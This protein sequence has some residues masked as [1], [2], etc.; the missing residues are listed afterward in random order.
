MG[1]RQTRYGAYA[2]VYILVVIAIVAAANFLANRYNR[3]YDSTA[4]KRYSL[5]DQTIKIVS[6]LKQDVTIAYF[7]E[8][9]ALA[10]GRDLLERY[11]ALSPKLKVEYNDPFKKPQLAKEYGITTTGTTVL[12]SGDKR[13]EARSLSE[14][15][16]TSA[17]VRLLKTGDRVACF[18]SGAGEHAL[19]ENSNNSYSGLKDLFEKNNYKTS[20]MNLLEKPEISQ[21]CSLVVVGGPK[22]DYPQPVVDALKKYVEA[23]GRALLLLDPPLKTGK[24]T[25]ADNNALLELARS[26]GVTLNKDMVVDTS[27]VGQLYGMGPEVALATRYENHA[28]VREM[29]RTAT[30]FPLVRSLE[31]KNGDKT[32]VEKLVSTSKNSLAA[33]NLNAAGGALQ[34]P[35]GEAQSYLIAAAGTY[36][37]G[38]QKDG[39][40]VDGRFVVAGSSDWVTNYALGFGGNRDLVMNMTNWLTNDED[41]ISIRPKDPEDRRIQMTRNQMLMV[42]MVSQF[43]IPLGAILLGFLV[44]W[45]RR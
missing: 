2:T 25:V 31:I 6:N 23:G 5:S 7:D 36:R 17:I 29:K 1:N 32:T 39:N 10:R 38:Q 30:A 21:G 15:E 9:T 22:R 13:Q 40:N 19:D 44:W 4:N 18:A 37:S 12:R 16:L 33:T 11:S 14:E 20:E 3:S 35:K 34:M 43:L 27:G 8:T 45:K 28:I 41:L 24:E 26:W 42:R